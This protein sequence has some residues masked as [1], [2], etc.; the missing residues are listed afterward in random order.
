MIN[1]NN[2]EPALAK[3]RNLDNDEVAVVG[4]GITSDAMYG[5]GITLVIAGASSGQPELVAAGVVSGGI[6]WL[7][8]MYNV[9][10]K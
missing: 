8:D 3:I 6:G 10:T 1:S 7:L 4:G 9:R 2:S 5:I